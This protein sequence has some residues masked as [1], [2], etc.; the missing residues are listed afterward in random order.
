MTKHKRPETKKDLEIDEAIDKLHAQEK[1]SNSNVHIGAST[2]PY[3]DELNLTKQNLDSLARLL[4]GDETCAA[5][6][7]FNNQL[8]IASNRKTPEYAKKYLKLLKDYI[9]APFS[10]SYKFLQEKQ[11][12]QITAT[13]KTLKDSSRWE[14]V[15]DNIK[16]KNYIKLVKAITTS[17]LESIKQIGE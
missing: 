17:D 3:Y 16:D 1:D 13:I 5:I 12:A 14:K 2:K 8:I 11:D 7:Y 6:C 4:T 15:L 10:A 9:D